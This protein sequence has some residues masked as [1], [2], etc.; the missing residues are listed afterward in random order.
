[1]T[2]TDDYEAFEAAAA[3]IVLQA[4]EGAKAKLLTAFPYM[5]SVAIERMIEKSSQY[6][7]DEIQAQEP[8]MTASK[9]RSNF[10]KLLPELRIYIYEMALAKQ[11]MPRPDEHAWEV[12]HH[13]EIQS[14]YCCDEPSS[15]KF[16]TMKPTKRP[17]LLAVNRQVRHEAPPV[18]YSVNTFT[19]TWAGDWQGTGGTIKKLEIRFYMLDP[20]QVGEC[21]DEAYDEKGIKTNFPDDLAD[22]LHEGYG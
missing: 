18:Y 6:F 11:K 19:A 12:E 17:A 20:D 15:D 22:C 2:T 16:I 10:F 21:M 5:S 9:T 1:M 3:S 14:W 7:Q 4:F 13:V 8:A